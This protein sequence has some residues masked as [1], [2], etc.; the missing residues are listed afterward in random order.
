M[1]AIKF[2]IFWQNF[3]RFCLQLNLYM[4]RQ[5]VIEL[6]QK[7]FGGRRQEKIL[8]HLNFKFDKI[9]M[10][11]YFLSPFFFWEKA[12]VSSIKRFEHNFSLHWLYKISLYW[13]EK[14]N[15]LM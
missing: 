4:R 9:S 7:M 8:L 2:E 14:D 15:G 12:N 10:I 13:A 3:I 6:Q 1:G 5:M 11:L